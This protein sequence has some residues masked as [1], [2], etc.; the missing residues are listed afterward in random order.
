MTLVLGVDGCRSGWC[1]VPVEVTSQV[2]VRPPFIATFRELLDSGAD[3]IAID[4]PIGLPH[5]A[6][7]RACDLEARRLLGRAWPRVFL[8]P[9]RAALEATDYRV[10]CDAHRRV[11]G[12]MISQQCFGILPK[13][14]EVD[15]AMKPAYQE[16]VLEAH[17]EL[18][19]AALNCGAP[20]LAGK[21]T[22]EGRAIRWELLRSVFPE[23]ASAP[24]SGRE[25]PPGCAADDYI[26][27]LACAWTA[28][29]A[30]R[31]TAR[32]VPEAP[33]TVARGLRME[34]WIP[35]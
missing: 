14:R 25:L 26:D 23:L 21:T 6:R 8:P 34:I 11:T 1:A 27:A 32:R 19:L 2:V 24:P 31:G 18:A 35:L 12:R 16:R 33:D 5:D 15:E 3:V 22:A 10:A 9:V 4:I 17:P 20:V 7:N 29:C 30:L 28:V 13:I